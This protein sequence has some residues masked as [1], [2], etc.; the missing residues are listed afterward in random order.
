[1]KKIGEYIDYKNGVITHERVEVFETKR[2]K[3]KGL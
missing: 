2:A 1:M 3:T